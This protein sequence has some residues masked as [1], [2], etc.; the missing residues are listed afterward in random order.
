MSAR[1]KFAVGLSNHFEF[2]FEWSLPSVSAIINGR[3]EFFNQRTTVTVTARDNE[4]RI[5]RQ[6]YVVEGY[7]RGVYSI[8]F[9]RVNEIGALGGLVSSI[10]LLATGDLSTTGLKRVMANVYTL[11][12]MMDDM[13]D[14]DTSNGHYFRK[15]YGITQL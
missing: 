12:L 10:M 4:F 6:D 8:P 9:G 5:L 11:V 1:Q 7:N 13:Q 2:E 14:L 3:E 15:I